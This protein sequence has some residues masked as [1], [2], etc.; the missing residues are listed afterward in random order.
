[1]LD[2]AHPANAAVLYYLQAQHPNAAPSQSPAAVDLWNLGTHL[3]LVDCLWRE[4][5]AALPTVTVIVPPAGERAEPLAFKR[6]ACAWVVYGLAALV[7]EESG[8]LFAFV[9]GTSTLAVR[10]PSDDLA[11]AFDMEGPRYGRA[12]Q[13][14]D[15]SVEAAQFGA[16]WVLV[17]P[18]SRRVEDWL[19]TAYLHVEMLV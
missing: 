11:R 15:S 19:V 14:P 12:Y 4:A 3:D 9:D 18:Y 16:D 5:S 2:L 13:Y 6:C 17:E 10:L 7:H 1:M 8:L